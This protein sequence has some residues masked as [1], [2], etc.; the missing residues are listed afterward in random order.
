MAPLLK[1]A[2]G[3]MSFMFGVDE[4]RYMMSLSRRLLAKRFSGFLDAP[5]S[6]PWCRS[7]LPRL[8]PWY[9]MY[10]RSSWHL[11]RFFFF[12]LSVSRS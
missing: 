5:W 1:L 8:Y 9:W 2:D 7:A 12:S 11:S 10:L 4:S 6:P 3:L